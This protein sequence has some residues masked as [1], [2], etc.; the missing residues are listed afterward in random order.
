MVLCSF[1][2]TAH[3]R[4]FRV[5]LVPFLPARQL[6][7]KKKYIVVYKHLRYYSKDTNSER[8]FQFFYKFKFSKNRIDIF[9]LMSSFEICFVK[10]K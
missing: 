1:L 10:M 3:L 9:N 5:S 6:T 8:Y 2:L 7:L 4:S